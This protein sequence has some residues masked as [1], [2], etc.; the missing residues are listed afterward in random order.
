MTACKNEGLPEP[1]F[2]AFGGGVL[3]TLF[4]PAD[5]V[6]D[7][8]NTQKHVEKDGIETLQKTDLEESGLKSGLKNGLKNGLKIEFQIIALMEEDSQI[9]MD[10]IALKL[11]RARSG[12]AKHL[13]AMQQKNMIRRVGSNKG[14][15]WEIIENENNK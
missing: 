8:D 10:E 7:G 14:G 12:I 9:T 1:R 13:K 15:H 11:Q 5:E 2:E 6:E 3:V 4:R